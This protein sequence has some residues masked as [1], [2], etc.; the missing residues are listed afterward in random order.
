MLFVARFVGARRL[1]RRAD[2]EPR[3]QIRQRGM[4]LPIG[5]DRREQIRPPQERALGGRHAAEHDVVAAAGAGVLA[6]EHELLGREARGIGVVIERRRVFDDLA[7]ARGRLHVD[8][9]HAR[10]RRHL[11]H[12]AGADRTAGH[13]PRCARAWR[14]WRPCPRAPASSTR[15]RRRFRAAA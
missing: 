11:E 2:E 9:D 7:P 14:C 5:D 3:E 4:V 15:S 10:I 8:F 1:A 12:S 13:S 6:V